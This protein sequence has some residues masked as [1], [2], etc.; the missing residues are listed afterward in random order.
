MFGEGSLFETQTTV[1]VTSIGD[2]REVDQSDFPLSQVSR[3][4]RAECFPLCGR[5]RASSV[6]LH[7]AAAL[8]AQIVY[9]LHR[10]TRFKIQPIMCSRL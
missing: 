10:L 5:Q 1:C 9:V 6:W 7:T 8:L 2:L 3:L 4:G